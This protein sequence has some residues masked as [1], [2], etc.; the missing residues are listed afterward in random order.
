MRF[1]L[2]QILALVVLIALSANAWALYRS[3]KAHDD[4]YHAQ[5]GDWHSRSCRDQYSL[6]TVQRVVE[7]LTLRRT[8]C[9]QLFEELVP[10][11]EEVA[12]QIEVVPKAGCISILRRPCYLHDQAKR[13]SISIPP[14]KP[15]QLVLEIDSDQNFVVDLKPGVH[16]L[17]YAYQYHEDDLTV[18]LNETALVDHLKLSGYSGRTYHSGEDFRKQNNF[19]LASTKMPIKITGLGVGSKFSIFVRDKP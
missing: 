6:T 14:D 1:S 9:E 12:S 5:Q 13:F 18:R 16:L 11:F 19:E 3:A 15:L 7:F 4:L 8:R 2:K 10:V 17:E